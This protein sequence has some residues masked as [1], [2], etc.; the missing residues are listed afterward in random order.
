[1][2]YTT[3]TVA[4][5][6]KFAKAHGQ[7]GTVPKVTHVGWGNGGYDDELGEV[8]DPSPNATVVPGEFLKKTIDV[9]TMLDTI[10]VRYVISLEKPEGNGQNVSSCGLYD[11][12]GTL[13]SIKNF[14]PKPKDSDT[15]ITI[16]WDEQF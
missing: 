15:L 2:A 8:I 6:A 14:I 4:A 13:V 3:T 12:E 9:I 16:Q 7:G 11:S 1:M 10:T 5:R